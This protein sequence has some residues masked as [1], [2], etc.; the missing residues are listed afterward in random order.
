[1]VKLPW[2]LFSK[3]LSGRVPCNGARNWC[4]VVLRWQT[5]LWI[6]QAS[7]RLKPTQF[8]AQ[9]VPLTLPTRSVIILEQMSWLSIGVY[10]CLES[11]TFYFFHLSSTMKFIAQCQP[12]YGLHFKLSTHSI[13]WSG[14][15]FSALLGS[16][17]LTHPI[18]L[19]HCLQNCNSWK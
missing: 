8:G 15:E 2:L 7:L 12:V 5:Y 6:L 10:R 3:A 19:S 4:W 1:M 17:A 11:W 18:S 14:H 16:E 13:G 9:K